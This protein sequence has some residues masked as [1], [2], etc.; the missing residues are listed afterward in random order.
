MQPNLIETIFI[1]LTIARRR[2]VSGFFVCGHYTQIL[3]IKET[4]T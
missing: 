2:M 4:I 3:K 1:A